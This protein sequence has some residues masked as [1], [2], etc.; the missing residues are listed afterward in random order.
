MFR[1]VALVSCGLLVAAVMAMPQTAEARTV[2]ARGTNVA[3]RHIS[4]QGYH[5][6]RHAKHRHHRHGRR[7]G[8]YVKHHRGHSGARSS[9]VNRGNQFARHTPRS[10]TGRRH[11]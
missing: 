3:T 9:M 8:Q 1:K 6:V 10:T 2:H 5:G 7:H 4:G 11:R